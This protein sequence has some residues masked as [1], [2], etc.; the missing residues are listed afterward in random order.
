MPYIA[1][2]TESAQKWSNYDNQTELK[3]G[4]DG[5]Q[6]VD[7]AKSA[8][9]NLKEVGK[10]LLNAVD[11]TNHFRDTWRDANNG[12]M[13]GMG[14]AFATLMLPWDLARE[15]LDIPLAPFKVIKNVGDA[16]A[17]GVMAGVEKVSGK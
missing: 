5:K 14:V 3:V 13:W 9:A 4:A 1:N 6:Q 10:N 12:D 7:H 11:P 8:I 2:G 17:H 16:A 15:L